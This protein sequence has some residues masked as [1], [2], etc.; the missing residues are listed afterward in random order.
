MAADYVDQV[1]NSIIDQL[2]KGTAPWVKPWGPGERFMPYN[3]TTGNEY[4]GGNAMWLMSQAESRDYDDARWL[5]FRQAQ[6]Q[7]AQ[8]RKGEKGTPIQ[9]WKWQGLEPV[10]NAHGKPMLDGEGNPV[11][12]LVRY[13]RPRVMSA[14]VFNAEQMNGLGPA[15]DRPA[16]P[17]WD[18]HSRAERILAGSGVDF[19]H[20]A[21][22][23]AF[24][25]LGKDR[26]T[27]PERWQF[28]TGDGYYATVL[29][30]LGHATGHPSRLNR[31]MAYP[32]GSEG[33]AREEM[34]AE[35]GSLMLGGQ[36]GIGHDPGQ[37]V[38]YIESWIRVLE[39]DPREV[40]RAAADAEKIVEMVRSFELVQE[41]TADQGQTAEASLKRLTPRGIA[42]PWQRPELAPRSGA[43][44]PASHYA[45]MIAA[46]TGHLPPKI[47]TEAVMRMVDFAAPDIVLPSDSNREYRRSVAVGG[48]G[49]VTPDTAAALY[50]QRS[51][52]QD[53]AQRFMGDAV[54]L[55]DWARGRAF[56]AGLTAEDADQAATLSDTLQSVRWGAGHPDAN[57]GLHTDTEGRAAASKAAIAFA[58]KGPVQASL[59]SLIRDVEEP[60]GLGG[61]F[62]MGTLY[63]RDDQRVAELHTEGIDRDDP[64]RDLLP[65][66]P[67]NPGQALP[68]PTAPQPPVMIRENHPA[69]TP[70][71]ERTYLAVPYAE[72]DAAKQ[73]GARWDKTERAWFVPAGVPVDAFAQWMPAKGSVHIDA[74]PSPRDAFAD[75]LRG[76]GL[77]LGGTPQ[78]DGQLH[79]V[80]V[81]GD[82]G[83]ERSGAYKGH[84]DGRPAGF[85]QN[86]KTGGE[87]VYWKANSQ[88]T[89]LTPQERAQQAAEAAKTRYERAHQREQ[90]YERAGGLADAIWETA[91]PVSQSAYLEGKGVAAEGLREGRYGQHVPV[92]SEDGSERQKSI[93]GMLIVPVHGADGKVS[94][95]QLIQPDGTKMF[96]PN[97]RM[98]GGHF[99]VGDVDKSGPL[100]IA[101]GYATAATVHELTGAPVIVAFTAGNLGKVAELYRA[102]YPERAIYI[103]GDTDREKPSNVGRIKAEEA[104]ATVGGKALF[105]AFPDGVKGTDWNDLAKA[106]G[107]DTAQIL[108]QAAMRVADRQLQAERGVQGTMPGRPGERGVVPTVQQTPPKRPARETADLE[109]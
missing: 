99:A 43:P 50:S 67:L 20:V 7:G 52:R 15:P 78:M 59:A 101:E 95:L 13:E 31:D 100:L 76:A 84:L 12:E 3:P 72:K 65:P 109:R 86:F 42:I 91:A 30:E 60:P 11:R 9:F 34:R 29:H 10:R 40:F 56:G 66:V 46:S 73:L 8:V 94:S 25:H 107:R 61:T 71:D 93:A 38:A 28:D 35:I 58:A 51:I 92:R 55:A 90:M 87:K 63:V 85:Y 102:Q 37:H 77:R 33:Y 2:H 47:R 96:L 69:M 97:G 82:N 6:E 83:R 23:R 24:Y 57:D 1:A 75:A 41:Q 79:R 62:S 36:L 44:Q 18:R 103:A 27:L 32:F 106:V 39:Q 64:G 48:V 14:V 81:E 45:G 26:I 108:M 68:Q 74:G 88:A 80:P 54:T 17:E 98:D 5:T 19:H 49:Q 16:L 89:A 70:S 22:D 105:P 104:A 53:D 21:G 4:R